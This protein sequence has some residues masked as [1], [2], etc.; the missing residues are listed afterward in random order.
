MTKERKL[1]ASILT[2]SNSNIVSQH[3]L[4]VEL[5]Q[6]ILEVMRVSK[7]VELLEIYRSKWVENETEIVHD[8]I[9]NR[10]FLRHYF[11]MLD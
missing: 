10:I 2:E 3:C 5:M 11:K 1:Y 6:R 7:K 8:K 9:A 4:G